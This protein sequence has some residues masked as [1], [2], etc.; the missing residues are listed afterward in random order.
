LQTIYS[1]ED[2]DD[3]IEIIEVHTLVKEE[4]YKEEDRARKASQ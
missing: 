3:F 4:H 2:L 1:C